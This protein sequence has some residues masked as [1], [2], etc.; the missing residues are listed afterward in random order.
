MMLRRIITV[1]ILIAGVTLAPILTARA[2]TSPPGQVLSNFET[3]FGASLAR[4]C[5]FSQPLPGEQGTSLWLFCDTPVFGFNSQKQWGF[6]YFIPGSTAAEGPTTRG[7]VPTD[8][9]ELP[10]TGTP[11]PVFPDHDAPAQ[12]LPTPAGLVTSEG[13]TCGPAPIY[14]ASWIYG[15]TRDPAQPSDLLITFDNFCV[16]GA[17]NFHPEGFGLDVYDP[18]TNTVVSHTVFKEDTTTGLTPQQ[19]LGSPVISGGYLYL[20]GLLCK[21]PA[22]TCPANSANAVYAARVRATPGAWDNAA[23]YRWFAGGGHWSASPGAAKSVIP[24]VQ[25]LGEVSTEDFRSVGQGFVLL[26][27]T[28]LSGAFTA[29]ESSSPAGPWRVKT[30]GTVPC[31][32]GMTLCHALIG[33]PDLSTRQSLLVSFLN[34]GAGNP[35]GHVE[36]AAFP[37]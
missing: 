27:Q 21:D 8:L 26:V 4:D 15:V 24:G 28:S 1:L 30:T 13:G 12:F 14:A 16:Q 31:T 33:H 34:P 18:S 32:A 19:V 6:L 7:E 29:Y 22:N 23:D 36:V 17:F 10:S 11:L 35:D 20:F 25:P 5:G 2:D 3:Y 9:S 37:W